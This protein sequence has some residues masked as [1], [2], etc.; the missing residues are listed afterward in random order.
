[1][2]RI[3]IDILGGD[4]APLSPIL[5]AMEAAIELQGIAQIV[6]IGD[7]IV[8]KEIISEHGGNSDLFEFIHTQEQIEM[9][10]H[11]V[12]SFLK[13]PNSSIGLGFS[14]LK[15]QELDAFASL[16][17][18]GAMLVGCMQVVK[19][20]PG[21]IRPCI[22]S[23]LPQ[24][25]GT[26]NLLLDVGTNA[27]CRPDVLYQFGVIGSLYSENVQGKTSPKVGLLNIGEEEEKGNML[28]KATYGLMKDNNHFNF[29]GNVEGRDLFNNS[30]DVIVC[31]GYT[32]NIVLKE[33]EAFYTMVKQ[34]GIKD[35]YFEKFN[36]ENYG[37]TPVLGINSN[38]II[39]HGKSSAKA[40][41]NMLV[42]AKDVVKADLP[43]Q[44]MKAFN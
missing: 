8:A 42:T 15:K 17:N 5:G 35:E 34:R 25:D 40:V 26:Y 10:D 2:M 39:G 19:T 37:G 33:A 16:G 28:T 36:Y 13:K 38:V 31:D 27:D 29:T 18:T 20:I 11:P 21:V 6:L 24:M 12:K 43:N 41:K 9:G 4:D 32:G 22:S 14:C 30:A 23:F 1:M 44:I 7:E 3:G